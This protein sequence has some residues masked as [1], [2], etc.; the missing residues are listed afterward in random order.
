MEYAWDGKGAKLLHL[1]WKHTKEKSDDAFTFLRRMLELGADVSVTDYY[2][3]NR[4][5]EAVSEA[6]N[7]CPV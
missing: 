6:N 1:E 2:G 4:L 5:T 7:L 3:R